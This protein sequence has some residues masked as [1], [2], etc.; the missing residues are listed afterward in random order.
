[1][2]FN[3][4]FL[5]KILQVTA[6]DLDTGN[7]ARITYRLIVA[8]NSEISDGIFGIFP[9][10]GWIYLRNNLD[11]EIQD[12]YKLTVA[13]IDNGTPSQTALS[14]VQVTVLDANDNDP[15]F[16]KTSYEFYVEE[17]LQRGARVGTVT[18]TDI[19]VGSNAAIKYNLI[20]SNTSFQINPITGKMLYYYG[21]TIKNCKC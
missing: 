13:A 4:F 15:I 5:F 18:A 19:D 6:I 9:N 7:N 10:S 2:N 14:Q 16:T 17:N 1:M 12:H 3:I 8:N 21:V 11:R 20:P